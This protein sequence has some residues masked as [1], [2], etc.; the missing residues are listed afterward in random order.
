MIRQAAILAGGKGTR[1]RPITY[2]L[3]K[4]MVPVNK[5]P[6]LEYLILYLKKQGIQEIVLLV[7]YKWETIKRHFGSGED[8]GVSITYSVEKNFLGT[9]GALKNA[10]HMLAET[11]FL[12]Y[13]DTYLPINYGEMCSALTL[14]AT[15]VLAV[16]TNRERVDRNNVHVGPDGYVLEYNKN[17][18]KE[19]MNGIE[20]GVSLFRREVLEYI[21]SG[22]EVS[23]EIEVYPK[24]IKNRRLKAYI[25][26]IRYYDMGTP[27]RLKKIAEVLK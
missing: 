24:L 13:G 22:R 11:F 12:L 6:F 7:G 10:E 3:P 4:C 21:P 8:F 23:L 16:Y 1:L 9:G 25:T 2:Q 15:G 27:E 20:A 26:N 19:Y 18:E 17:E 14:D 5:R